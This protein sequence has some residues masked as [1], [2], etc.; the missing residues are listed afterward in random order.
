M[1]DKFILTGWRIADVTLLAIALCILL[2]I[3]LGASS[4]GF[5]AD[6][7]ANAVGM[8][9]KLPP[10]TVIGLALLVFLWKRVKS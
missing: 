9:Q 10:G 1:I 4:G 6:V 8:L 5:I 7:S 3:I 2:N